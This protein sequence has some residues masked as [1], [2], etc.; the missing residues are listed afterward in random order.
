MI[1]R[2]LLLTAI[3]LIFV[4][5]FFANQRLAEPIRADVSPLWD[6]RRIVSLAPSIT[7]TLYALGLGDRVV[8]VTRYC[9]YPPD[10][11]NK[12]QVG[13]YYDMNLEAIM[14]LKPDL[15]IMLEEQKQASP[16]ID[17]VSLETLVVSHKTI[18]GIIDSFRTIGRVCGEGAK[19]RRMARD[20]E[21]R[22]E[23]IRRQTQGLSRP[24]V[25]FALDR[26]FGCGHLADVYIAGVDGYFD[27]IIELAGGQNVYTDVGVRSPVV[28]PEGILR[29]NPDVIIDLV[30]PGTR[31]SLDRKTML[32]DWDDLP[33]VAAVKNHRVFV[34]DEDY[35]CVPGPRFVQLVEDLAKVLH[36][37]VAW[38]PKNVPNATQPKP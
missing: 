14:A 11:K 4:A 8:G 16:E 32:A 18:A 25:L 24:R 5:S 29:L 30:P 20:L 2:V 15:V 9:K 17:Q 28:S 34:F 3:T 37:E 33:Q 13:G 35:A 26:T 19:G 6:C 10:A 1:Q 22:L 12:T 23:Q 7:E 21:N 38:E 31:Q 27:K 36:P